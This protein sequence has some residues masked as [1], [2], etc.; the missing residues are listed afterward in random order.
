MRKEIEF[1]TESTQQETQE[2]ITTVT[3]KE[4]VP[5]VTGEAPQKVYHKKKAIFR[6]YQVIW[7]ILGAIEILLGFRVALKTLGANP[8]SGFTHLIYTLSDPL[9]LP[10]SGILSA[11]VSGSSVFEWS[12]FFAVAVYALVAYGLVELM[13]F[14]KPVTKEEVE[15]GVD[16]Q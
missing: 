6:T 2:Q 7:Y 12:T 8:L 3:K 4:V 16:S 11:T 1:M 9:A 15:Q 14:V 13:Q 10:F 5:Q